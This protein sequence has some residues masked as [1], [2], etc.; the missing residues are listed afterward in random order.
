MHH[1]A[2]M[3]SLSLRI[4]Q[5]GAHSGTFARPRAADAVKHTL[6]HDLHTLVRDMLVDVAPL[7]RL[8]A[9]YTLHLLSLAMVLLVRLHVGTRHGVPALAAADRHPAASCAML[10]DVSALHRI[11]AASTLLQHVRALIQMLL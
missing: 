6:L 2:Q 8:V 7:H 11:L 3:R 10:L 1:R 5:M 9:V 4:D